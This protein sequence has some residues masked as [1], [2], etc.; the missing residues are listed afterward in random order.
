MH[1]PFAGGRAADPHLEPG[2]IPGP[3]AAFLGFGTSTPAIGL[4]VARRDPLGDCVEAPSVRRPRAAA[5]RIGGD[6]RVHAT[7]KP[8]H[9]NMAETL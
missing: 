5:G 8:K 6:A 7:R 9:G 3:R 1:G 2:Q 4:Q